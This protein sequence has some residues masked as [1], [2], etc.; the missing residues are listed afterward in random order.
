MSRPAPPPGSVRPSRVDR[1]SRA[2]RTRRAIAVGVVATLLVAGLGV[3][4]V[5]RQDDPG[6][7][8]GG[9]PASAEPNTEPSLVAL[10]VNGGPA[11]LLAVVGAPIDGTPFVMPLSPQLTLVVPGQGETSAAGVAA[12]PGDS[13]RVG[14]SNMT[15]VWIPHYAVLSLRDLAST[16]DAAG[17][18]AVNL[19]SA[20]P[21]KSGVLGPGQITMTGAQVKS[22]LAGSTDDAEVRWEI[23]LTAWLADPPELVAQVDS[24][25]DD[26]EAV[27]A[28]L[29]RARGA[30][31]LEMPTE[32]VTATIVVPVYPALDALVSDSLG[33]PMPVPAIVQNGSG[34]PG[35][36]EAVAVRILPAGFRVVLAQNA[37]SFDVGRTDVFANGPDHESEAKAVKAALG[38]GRVRV[39][40]VPSNV[41]DITIVVGKD[42]T[43]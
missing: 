27:N 29:G 15:G 25:V 23:F 10:Q 39:A 22:F 16:V 18:L 11:P 21:T 26:A 19:Q 20:Y 35:V 36:G 31:V 38:V 37:Q 4:L 24:E 43:A 2:R 6:G 8:T 5:S 40:A 28:A 9:D 17:G 3:F 12:L 7:S 42:F 30:E 41:G 33:T 13:M 14:L 1:A 32:R 34:E